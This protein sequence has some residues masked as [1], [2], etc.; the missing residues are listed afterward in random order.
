MRARHAARAPAPLRGPLPLSS[1]AK[2]LGEVLLGDS[3]ETQT[4]F[5]LGEAVALIW[6]DDVLVR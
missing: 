2:V 5:W 3:L 4:V 6:E 1:A